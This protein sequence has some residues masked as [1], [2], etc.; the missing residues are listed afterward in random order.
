MPDLADSFQL[1]Q[2]LRCDI[3]KEYAQAKPITPALITIVR[4]MFAPY[5]RVALEEQAL[6]WY[7]I[8]HSKITKNN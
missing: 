8:T 1:T 2:H 5:F 7:I 3:L 4:V 6:Q